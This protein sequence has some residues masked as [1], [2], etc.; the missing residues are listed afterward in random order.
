MEAPPS[1]QLLKTGEDAPTVAQGNIYTTQNCENVDPFVENH[2]SSGFCS[3]IKR[4]C[5]MSTR[6]GQLTLEV[7]VH[8][9]QRTIL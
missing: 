8:P 3:V 6:D 5:D 9:Q 7:E 4:W 2:F 1:A